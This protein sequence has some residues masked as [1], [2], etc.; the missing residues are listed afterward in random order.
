MPRKFIVSRSTVGD[1]R[2]ATEGMPN[3]TTLWAINSRDRDEA[4]LRPVK[5]IVVTKEDLKIVIDEEGNSE[6]TVVLTIGN[7]EE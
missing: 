4:P 5:N 6:K 7:N 1:F 3:D 2:K